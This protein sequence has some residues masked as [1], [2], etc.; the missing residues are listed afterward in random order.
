MEGTLLRHP[1]NGTLVY[2]PHV[3]NDPNYAIFE[4]PEASLHFTLATPEQVALFPSVPEY[5][6]EYEEIT[7]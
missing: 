4:R 1:Y 7:E 6:G 3:W 2:S 5:P